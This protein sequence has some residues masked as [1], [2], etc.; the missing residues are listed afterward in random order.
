[1]ASH[2][3][4]AFG[5]GVTATASYIDHIGTNV[6]ARIDNRAV[7]NSKTADQVTAILAYRSSADCAIWLPAC[8]DVSA[9]L[10]AR[11]LDSLRAN[12]GFFLGTPADAGA[13]Q[14]TAKRYGFVY[15]V[16]TANYELET[17]VTAFMAPIMRHA[18]ILVLVPDPSL[19]RR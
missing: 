8:G 9:A 14:D 15:V 18:L 3:W 12:G 16:E 5:D 11:G 4:V 2:Q 10:L 7:P 6:G 19:P 17:L 1:L 13:T